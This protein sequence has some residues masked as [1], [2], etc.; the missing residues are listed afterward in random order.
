MLEKS[1]CDTKNIDSLM[2]N[3]L[4]NHLS[5]WN[6]SKTAGIV[7]QKTTTYTLTQATDVT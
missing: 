5:L 2:Q 7:K 3:V 1:D 6:Y 4:Q